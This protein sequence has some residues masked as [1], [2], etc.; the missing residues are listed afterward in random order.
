M[1][2]KLY[3]ERLSRML[4]P[5]RVQHS[6]G[7]RDTAAEMARIHGAGVEQAAVAGLLH[8]CARSLPAEKLLELALR[9]NIHVSRVDM[10]LPVILHAPVGA[11]LARREFGVNDEAI[12]RAISLHTL[13]DAHMSILD[14]VLFVADKVEP[15]RCFSGVERIRALA[16]SDLDQALLAC[17]DLSITYAIRCGDP[18]HPVMIDARNALVLSRRKMNF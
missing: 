18:V 12:L 17:Y 1:N 5:E 9:F 10:A 2:E 6:L 15:G 11:E 3:L 7:V 14:K 16:R 4:E 13:G 8:D